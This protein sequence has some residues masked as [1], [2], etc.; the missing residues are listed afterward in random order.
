MNTLCR[1][2]PRDSKRVVVVTHGLVFMF[3]V[4][5]FF[6]PV[7]SLVLEGVEHVVASV[8]ASSQDL[9]LV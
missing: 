8:H 2:E 3:M 5:V 7:S 9:E 4:V 1:V 6:R